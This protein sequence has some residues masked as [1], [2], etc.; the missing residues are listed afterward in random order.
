MRYKLKVNKANAD[1]EK[2]DADW[3]KANADRYKARTDKN[4]ASD[5]IDEL[6]KGY[7]K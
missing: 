2:A 5:K 7:K 3:E 6:H 4:K 1:W